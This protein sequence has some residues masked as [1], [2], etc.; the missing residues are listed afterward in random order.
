MLEPAQRLELGDFL[1][2]L[3]ATGELDQA[4]DV[5]ATWLERTRRVIRRAKIAILI[6]NCARLLFTL[7]RAFTKVRTGRT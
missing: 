2:A 3:V 7:L 5:I 1:E 6:L 4:D